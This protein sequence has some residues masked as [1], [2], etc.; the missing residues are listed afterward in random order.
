MDYDRCMN[1][2]TT[3]ISVYGLFVE[4]KICLKILKL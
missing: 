1:N 3:K 2:R 4:P